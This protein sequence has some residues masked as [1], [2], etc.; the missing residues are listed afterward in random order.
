MEIRNVEKN[1]EYMDLSLTDK[2][3]ATYRS[4]QSA[5]AKT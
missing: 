5:P 3:Q 4:T 1:H 2:K